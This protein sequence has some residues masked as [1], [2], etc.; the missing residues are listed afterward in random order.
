MGSGSWENETEIQNLNQELERLEEEEKWL[1]KMEDA[2]EDQLDLMA[3]DSQ[4]T[5]VTYN[6]IK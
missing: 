2:I 5:Y 6:D 3:K 1:A 4:Y